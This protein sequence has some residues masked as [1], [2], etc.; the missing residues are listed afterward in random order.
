MAFLALLNNPAGFA[1]I[2]FLIGLLS[3]AGLYA[4]LSATNR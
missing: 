1:L 3:I 2:L 4:I